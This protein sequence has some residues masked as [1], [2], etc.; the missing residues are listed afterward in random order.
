MLEALTADGYGQRQILF[1]LIALL[2]P[3]PK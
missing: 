3:F 1:V 2:C